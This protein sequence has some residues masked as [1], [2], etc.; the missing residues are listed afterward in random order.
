M[1]LF[2]NR[3]RYGGMYFGSDASSVI[4]NCTI[5]FNHVLESGRIFY[6]EDHHIE[7]NTLA[8]SNSILWGNDAESPGTS[9]IDGDLTAA[10]I[11]FSY[12]DVDTTSQIK[13]NII[14]WG[15]G[16]LYNIDPLF[17][18]YESRN[19]LLREHSPCIDAGDPFMDIGSESFPH[20]YRINMGGHGGTDK[21]QH[22]SGTKLTVLPLIDFG[23]IEQYQEIVKTVYLKN[24]SIGTIT[25]TGFTLSDTMN[26]EFLDSVPNI[27]CALEPMVLGPGDID[28]L[29]ICFTP[30]DIN[31][32]EINATLTISML[33]IPDLVVQ[34]YL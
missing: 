26:F 6:I 25:I 15:E 18:N 17:E 27:A 32:R 21:A 30:L 23:E 11:K 33:E 13:K 16:M 34:L 9:M 19:F 31:E 29:R 8:V 14:V 28:S 5:A 1:F 7:D 20:G 12:S 22:T 4:S 2:D 3:A 10:S 24:G